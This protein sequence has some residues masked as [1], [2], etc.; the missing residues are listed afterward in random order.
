[1]GVFPVVKATSAR[2]D[3]GRIVRLSG[4]RQ[5]A[6]AGF[7]VGRT[8]RPLI[9]IAGWTVQD[10]AEEL[11]TSCG[12]DLPRWSALAETFCESLGASKVRRAGQPPLVLPAVPTSDGG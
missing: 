12:V 9:L 1:M 6:W 5:L 10:V 4:N 11:E 8:W 7:Q 2:N 3:I